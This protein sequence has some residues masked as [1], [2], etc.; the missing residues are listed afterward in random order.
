MIE[1][2]LL[3]CSGF[4]HRFDEVFHEPFLIFKALLK[5]RAKIVRFLGLGGCGISG[6]RGG[7]NSGGTGGKRRNSIR[8]GCMGKILDN[9]LEIEAKLFIFSSGFL[10]SLGRKGVSISELLF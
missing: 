10:K 9:F 1:L 6:S 2:G 8:I 7:G 5:V 3:D 4:L